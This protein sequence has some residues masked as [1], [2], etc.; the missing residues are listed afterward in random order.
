MGNFEVSKA[1]TPQKFYVSIQP[2]YFNESSRW[3]IAGDSQGKNPNIYSEIRWKNLS[4]PQIATSAQYNF[5]KNFLVKV[6]IAESFITSGTVTDTDF[7]ADNRKD[8]LYHDSFDSDK[9]LITSLIV[10]IGYNL[11]INEKISITPFVGYGLNAQ[12]LYLLKNFGSVSGNLRSTYKT[13][14]SGITL[15]FTSKIQLRR[16]IIEPQLTYHQTNYTSKANWN[17]IENFKHPVSFRHKAIGFGIE[18]GLKVNF[19]MGKNFTVFLGGAAS[20][21]ATGKGSDKLYL[22]DG[23]VPVTQFN[24]SVR[25]G[26]SV[27]T[28]LSYSF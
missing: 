14:W 20:Y 2:G 9:G 10:A 17:L 21:W 13:R 22:A 3:S 19:K 12:S 23:Q 28:G 5:W 24:G 25:K 6:N 11:K 8:T 26:T 27:F 18:P 16:F 4:G 15:G 1:Q 7:G